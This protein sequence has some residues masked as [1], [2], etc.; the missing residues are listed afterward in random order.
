MI[1]NA[2]N[3]IVA[4]IVLLANNDRTFVI[5]MVFLVVFNIIASMA[6]KYNETFK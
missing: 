3:F 5:A 1:R 2:V 6:K 4:S